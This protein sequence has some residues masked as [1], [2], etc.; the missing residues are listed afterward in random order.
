[1]ERKPRKITKAIESTKKDNAAPANK[2]KD[3][4]DPPD[5]DWFEIWFDRKSQKSFIIF[6]LTAFSESKDRHKW[7][8]L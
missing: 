1:M 6:I 4:D 7:L 2:I 3:I 5:D 8:H